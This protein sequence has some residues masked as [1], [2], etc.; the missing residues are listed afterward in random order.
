MI[1]KWQKIILLAHNLPLNWPMLIFQ[2]L[3]FNLSVNSMN[4]KDWNDI[5][6]DTLRILTSIEMLL[7]CNSKSSNN[8]QQKCVRKLPKNVK[9]NLGRFSKFMRGTFHCL[10]GGFLKNNVIW[11]QFLLDCSSQKD[12]LRKLSKERVGLRKK[13]MFLCWPKHVSL[14]GCLVTSLY[15]FQ[16]NLQKWFFRQGNRTSK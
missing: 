1:K 2:N 10:L 13:S 8:L 16:N 14:A 3:H 15:A 5:N 11:E 4:F 7:I 12:V 9:V 6:D